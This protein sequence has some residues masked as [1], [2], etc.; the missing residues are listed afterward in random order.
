MCGTLIFCV[1]GTLGIKRQ[2]VGT[3]FVFI[4][5]NSS[6]FRNAVDGPND[7]AFA[8]QYLLSR[9]RFLG[10]FYRN[11]NRK[12]G[13]QTSAAPPVDTSRFVTVSL[14]PTTAVFSS[15]HSLSLASPQSGIGTGRRV[16]ISVGR[17]SRFFFFP[18]LASRITVLWLGLRFRTRIITNVRLHQWPSPRFDS[19]FP[20]NCLYLFI[21]FKPYCYYCFFF[22]VP[23]FSNSRNKLTK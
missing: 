9:V 23:I 3:I 10:L 13:P 14:A 12:H 17:H 22:F 20:S 16:S 1:V 5:P 18:S 2:W 11:G 7:A 21:Y 6:F 8:S 15:D 4:R 19:W